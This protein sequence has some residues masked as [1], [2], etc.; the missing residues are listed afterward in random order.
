MKVILKEDVK[1][2]GA[3][4]EVKEVRKGHA[5]NF[6]IPRNLALIASDANTKVYADFKRSQGK[7]LEKEKEHLRKV[8]EQIAGISCNITV[9]A[10]EDEKLYGSV[11]STDI[12]D[13]LKKQGVE[14]DKRKIVLEEPIKKTG[15]YTVPVHLAP[16]IEASLKLWVIKQ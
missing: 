12:A 14:I 13:A 11:T 8:A 9:Q 7:K 6:L 5:E 10:G 15:V 4:G 16:E 1:G 3:A 2:L